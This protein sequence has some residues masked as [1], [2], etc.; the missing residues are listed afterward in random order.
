MIV[1]APAPPSKTPMTACGGLTIEAYI[2]PLTS[3]VIGVFDG[4]AGATTI[5]R[6]YAGNELGHQSGP[7]VTFSCQSNKWSHIAFTA[8]STHMG[9][10]VNGVSAGTTAISSYG[11]GNFDI[12]TINTGTDGSFNGYISNFRVSNTRVYTANFTPPTD[13]LPITPNT[14]MLTCTKNMIVDD[15]GY[16]TFT[17]NGNA[18]TVPFS[19]FSPNS[20]YTTANTG[21]S[22]YFDGTGDYITIG[23]GADINLSTLDFSMEFW[24]YCT[25]L[26]SY[27]PGIFCKRTGGVASGW[28]MLTSGFI[29]LSGGTWYDSWS[30]PY[31]VGST[32][33]TGFNNST[34]L[35]N[36]GQWTHVVLTRQGSGARWFVNGKL[37]GYQSRSSAIDQLTGVPF[38]VGFGGATSEQPYTGYVSD[39]RI[40]IGS[41]PTNYQTSSTTTGTQIFTPPTAPLT[42]TSQG[43]L[44]NSV[45]LLM[46]YTDAA[47]V[48]STGKNVIETAGDA[49]VNNYVYKFNTGAMGFDGSGDYLQIYNPQ[50]FHFGA[51]NFTIEMFAKFNSSSGTQ[52]LNNYGY[53]PSGTQ[54]YVFYYS[55]GAIRLAYYSG[56]SSDASLG[57]FTPTVGTWYHIALVRNG[58]TV[59]CYVDG[60]ALGSPINISTNVINFSGTSGA[61]RIAVNATDYFAG[62]INEFRISKIARYTSNFT[63]PTRTF[64]NR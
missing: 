51:G 15:A 27:A 24:Y 36:V 60:V 1:V 2:Y 30:N 58:T 62:H 53:E 21:G 26:G 3:S 46:N 50:L 41:V 28:A 45:V 7:K 31:W 57:S 8:N 56:S 32:A 5:I 11:V 9:V 13:T 42:L 10:F 12:G 19:P 49:K 23:S 20:A 64:P 40:S 43:A 48:D 54:S 44:A 17:V 14:V 6:N 16:R 59:T 52:V 22:A 33:S 25:A 63:P 29:C 61:F 37:L 39:G 4:G 38:A 18:R 47:I 55:A 35:T 34:S